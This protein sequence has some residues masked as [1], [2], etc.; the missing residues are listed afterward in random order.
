[1]MIT[2]VESISD[3]QLQRINNLIGEAFVTNELFHNWGPVPERHDDV[4]K[5][6]EIYVDYTYRAGELYANEDLTGFIG[7]EDT[8]SAP[9]FPRLKMIL[10]LFRAFEWKKVQSLLGFV[11]QIS[12]SNAL[13]ARQRHLDILMVCVDPKQQGKG[14]ATELVQFAKDQATEKQIPLLIDTD[15]REYADMYQHLGCTLYNT[16][17]ADNGVTRYS[18]VW[19]PQ[20]NG[21]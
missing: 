4:L 5:Y 20:G 1:M 3:G 21:T 2:K 13:Y 19:Q 12:G 17:T 11:R 6:M 9:V 14:I 16:V 7:L 15:M 18:L 10:R 8:V